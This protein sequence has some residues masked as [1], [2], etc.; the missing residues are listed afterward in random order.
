MLKIYPYIPVLILIISIGSV[1]FIEPIY[2]LSLIAMGSMSLYLSN[3]NILYFIFYTLYS[4]FYVLYSILYISC[5]TSYIEN[6]WL[7][8]GYMY[9]FLIILSII[10]LAF[11]LLLCLMLSIKA[12]QNL[13][14]KYWDISIS[15]IC[16]LV[17]ILI[18]QDP[19]DIKGITPYITASIVFIIF[20]VRIV[21]LVF[22]PDPA[23]DTRPASTQAKNNNAT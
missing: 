5:I 9:F 4:I 12:K 13:F 18:N 23:E 14:L 16:I 20:T 21:T 10:S 2:A 19:S 22:K 11:L 7:G 6:D 15:T 17:N 8:V 3:V 1:F